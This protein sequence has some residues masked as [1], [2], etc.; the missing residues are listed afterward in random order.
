MEPIEKAVRDFVLVLEQRDL[1][2]PAYVQEARRVF[3]RNRLDPTA[4]GYEFS[5][6]VYSKE[7]LVGHL[8][9]SKRRMLQS[10]IE[11]LR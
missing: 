2:L 9:A 1:S 10:I 4:A 5:E 8:S 3:Q 7:A 6:M 11:K